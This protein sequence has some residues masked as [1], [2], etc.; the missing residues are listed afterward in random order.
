VPEQREKQAA[1]E[2]LGAL[3]SQISAE[4]ALETGTRDVLNH[5]PR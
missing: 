5:A 1:V 2:I 4:S 3:L